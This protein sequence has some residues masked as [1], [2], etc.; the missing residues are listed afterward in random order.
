M[1][2]AKGGSGHGAA[3]LANGRVSDPGT[4]AGALGEAHLPFPWDFATASA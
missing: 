2:K 1:W 3:R 4:L